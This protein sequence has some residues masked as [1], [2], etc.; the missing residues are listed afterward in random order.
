VLRVLAVQGEWV[1]IKTENYEGWVRKQYVGF[2]APIPPEIITPALPTRT[3][4]P[5][6]PTATK[7]AMSV[8]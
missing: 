6:T 7:T 8:S 5:A 4:R 3:P 2:T 1:K